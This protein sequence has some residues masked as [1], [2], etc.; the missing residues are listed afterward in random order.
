MIHLMSFGLS[1]HTAN[2]VADTT[3]NRDMD[4]A[5][6]RRFLHGFNPESAGL[7]PYLAREVRQISGALQ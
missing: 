5:S 4:Q 2:I 6:A 3:I 7:S 1:R